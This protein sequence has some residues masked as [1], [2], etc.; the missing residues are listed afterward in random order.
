MGNTELLGNREDL[1]SKGLVDLKEVN[2]FL[3]LS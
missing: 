3:L 2:V 1:G